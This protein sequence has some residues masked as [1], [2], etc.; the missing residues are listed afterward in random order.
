MLRCPLVSGLDQVPRNIDA[1]HVRS[2]FRRWQRRGAIAASEI[3][4]LKSFGDSESLHERLSAF[5]H[6]L[7][8][9]REVASFPECFVGIHRSAISFNTRVFL[10]GGSTW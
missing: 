3:Q 1:Q 7:G 6:G 9:A 10:H 5:A 8:N 4:N 2:Q